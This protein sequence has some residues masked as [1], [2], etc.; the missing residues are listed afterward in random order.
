[1]DLLGKKKTKMEITKN[2]YLSYMSIHSGILTTIIYIEKERKLYLKNSPYGAGD[3]E[4]VLL[5][6]LIDG[7]K[8]K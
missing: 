5:D 4:F 2:E 8:R 6:D 3:L 1:M 7:I